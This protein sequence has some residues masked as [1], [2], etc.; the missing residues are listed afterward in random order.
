MGLSKTYIQGIMLYDFKNDLK[1][2]NSASRINIESGED[3]VSQ[4]TTQD[5]LTHFH[6]GD[7]E[8]EG[9]PNLC[10]PSGANEESLRQMVKD[11]SQKTGS[12]LA[13]ALRYH[14]QPWLSI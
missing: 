1:P 8:V 12:Q 11:D 10:S 7:H 13:R 14:S 4:C 9:G 2:A 6:T 5:R 3:N